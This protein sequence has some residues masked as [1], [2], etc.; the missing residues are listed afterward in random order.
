MK[1]AAQALRPSA[2]RVASA[3]NLRTE[4]GFLRAQ[5]KAT[6]NLSSPQAN[7]KDL[8]DKMANETHWN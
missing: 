3:G 7:T 6:N 8:R 4:V 2:E 5:M 1:S